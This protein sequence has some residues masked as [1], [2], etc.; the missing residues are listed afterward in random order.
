MTSSVLTINGGSSSIKFALFDQV[1]PPERSLAGEVERIGLADTVIRAKGANGPLTGD[2]PSFWMIRNWL[3]I[4]AV[5]P[6][7]TERVP[8]SETEP[9]TSS[10]LYCVPGAVPLN[11]TF[12]VPEDCWLNGPVRVRVPV[13]AAA[14]SWP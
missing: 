12:N 11:C 4:A 6:T 14:E 2:E 10:R 7:C 5:K 13:E 9:F 8:A 3:P 1:E